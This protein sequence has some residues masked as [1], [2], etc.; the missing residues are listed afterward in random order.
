MKYVCVFLLGL[1]LSTSAFAKSFD[2]SLLGEWHGVCKKWERD[3]R[4]TSVKIIAQ[5]LSSESLEYQK[6]VFSDK[7]CEDLSHEIVWSSSPATPEKGKIEF[8]LDSITMTARTTKVA[9]KFSKDNYCNGSQWRVN[10][11]MPIAGVL[12]D[13]NAF[14]PVGFKAHNIYKVKNKYKLLLNFDKSVPTFVGLPEKLP[15]EEHELYKRPKM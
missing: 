14:G 8:T 10:K 4:G 5:F 7:H 13:D 1:G 9:G 12:C 6:L 15:S 3:D 2:K 11:P